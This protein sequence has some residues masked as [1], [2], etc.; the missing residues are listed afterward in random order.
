MGNGFCAHSEQTVIEITIQ[1][2]E[3]E[4]RAAILG[5]WVKEFAPPSKF[6]TGD[7]GAGWAEVMRQVRQH[8]ETLDLSAEIAAAAKGQLASVVQ[9]AVAGALR[10][11]AKKQV[12]DMKRNGTLIA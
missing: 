11:E 8:I 1:L 9:E 10:A 6:G 12:A 3:A 7:V 2:D 5:A 4:M